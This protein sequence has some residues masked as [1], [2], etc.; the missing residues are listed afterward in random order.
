MAQERAHF[1]QQ[2]AL[3]RDAYREFSEEKEAHQKAKI[4]WEKEVLS[5]MAKAPLDDVKN[6][7][8][9]SL[10]LQRSRY[11]DNDEDTPTKA[12]METSTYSVSIPHDDTPSKISN[13]KHHVTPVPPLPPQGPRA[14][15]IQRLKPQTHHMNTTPLLRPGNQ[16]ETPR[17]LM[18]SRSMT[19]LGSAMKGVVLS[20]T[21]IAIPTPARKFSNESNT[22][23]LH[24]NSPTS[25]ACP[26]DYPDTTDTQ[27]ESSSSYEDVVDTKNVTA[28]PRVA[29][30]RS[31]AQPVPISSNR[32]N[33]PPAI[34]TTLIPRV[35]QQGSIDKGSL[36]SNPS[37]QDSV[38]A[39]ISSSLPLAPVWDFTDEENLPSPFMKRNTD[40]SV[41]AREGSGSGSGSTSGDG[42]YAVGPETKMAP[43]HVRSISAPSAK[44]GRQSLISQAVKASGEAQRALARRQADMKPG[45]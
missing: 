14:P 6:K 29:R 41:Y 13:P 7:P 39:A 8:P 35:H 2:V 23:G 43:P 32:V 45:M 34:P 33:I 18:P 9:R 44:T 5:R 16:N 11:A 3:A 28:R 31:I 27:E 37:I 30:R 22:A 36:S 26:T 20:D 19:D 38:N 1:D 40:F 4:E 12:P 17:R 21:G 25:S 15:G 24:A 42:K 10:S